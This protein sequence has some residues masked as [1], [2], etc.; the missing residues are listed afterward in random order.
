M[1]SIYIALFQLSS[2]RLILIITPIDDG[3]NLKQSQLTGKY[4]VRLPVRRS[5]T[6]NLTI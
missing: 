1:E 4:T 6:S 3:I 5:K 2:K